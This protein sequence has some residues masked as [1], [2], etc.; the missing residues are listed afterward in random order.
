[1]EALPLSFKKNLSSNEV[2]AWE[3]ASPQDR[4]RFV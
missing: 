3:A 4:L 1:L 2:K